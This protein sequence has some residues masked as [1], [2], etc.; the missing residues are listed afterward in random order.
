MPAELTTRIPIRDRDGRVVDEKEVATYAGLL[1]RAHEEGL[2][3]V[4]TSLVQ[5][6]CEGNGWTAI[7]EATVETSRGRFTGIGDAN[8]G[9]VNRKIAPHLIR[10]A[11][12][13]A[14]ARALRD[15]VNIGLVAL[16]ELGGD[17]ES[18]APAPH[19]V[20][21]LPSARDERGGTREPVFHR[22][23][24]AERPP[25]RSRAPQGQSTPPAG[26]DAMSEAQRRLL[27][28][29]MSEQG[30]E[31]EQATQVLLEQTG[32]QTLAQIT[33]RE[34]SGLIDA[35]RARDARGA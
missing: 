8:E 5:A 10:M 19:N 29:L 30:Y 24:N 11:E 22:R 13:R 12:T 2:K 18:D 31:G 33:K 32:V 4:E 27:F 21:P 17:V 9:N 1:A 16:E 7:C 28:R 15:A 26:S 23:N 6:P 35:W 3:L 14:K 34:A 25:E 20:R